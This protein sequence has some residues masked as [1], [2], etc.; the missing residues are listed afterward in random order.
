M[1]TFRLRG[2][3][4]EGTFPNERVVLIQDYKGDNFALLVQ[5][6]RVQET[7]DNGVIEVK[8]LGTKDEYTLVR[9]PGELLSSGHTLS[10]KNSQLEP[11]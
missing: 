4:S 8:A 5:A 1:G 3:V 2:K 11:V 7:G 10:V 6:G 9:L